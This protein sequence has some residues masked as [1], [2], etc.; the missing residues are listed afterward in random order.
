MA[1]A[2]LHVD[3]QPAAR[4]STPIGKALP[5]DVR[6]AAAGRTRN[7]A[8]WS[9][10]V[11]P[12]AYEPDL[13]LAWRAFEDALKTRVI[14]EVS[15]PFLE[16]A[17]RAILK[18]HRRATKRGGRGQRPIVPGFVRGTLKFLAK[19]AGIGRDTM[20]RAVRWFEKKGLLDTV[21]ITDRDE[22]GEVRFQPNMYLV[23]PRAPEESPSPAA[24][25]GGSGPQRSPIAEHVAGVLARWSRY[26]PALEPRTWGWNRARGPLRP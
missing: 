15:G 22:E 17:W 14:G 16:R 12:I 11:Q 1:A 4:P 18:L 9:I 2:E 7:P 6:S 23:R 5:P 13:D 20:R 19:V 26:L 24:T 10:D 3:A 25:A 21:N 8:L